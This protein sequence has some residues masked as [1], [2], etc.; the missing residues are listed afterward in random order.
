MRR[1]EVGFAALLLVV[2]AI[3]AYTKIE[4]GLLS[5]LLW[6]CNVTAA[7][8]AIGTLA[9]RPIVTSVGWLTFVAVGFPLWLLDQAFGGGTT[10]PSAIAHVLAPLVGFLHIRRAGL[11]RYSVQG[12]FGLHVGLL[13]LSVGLTEPS[14]NINM[15]HAVWP[16][17]APWFGELWLYQLLNLT[18][19]ASALGAA[20]LIARRLG[21]VRAGPAEN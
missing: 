13:L 14:L 8:I 20:F 2:L 10:W 17:L 16:P 3:H 18:G 19:G 6:S 21:L 11:W 12:A 7:L 5:E 15:A 9:D 4:P 1:A